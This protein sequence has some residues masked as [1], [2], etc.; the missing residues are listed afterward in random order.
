MAILAPTWGNVGSILTPTSPSWFQLGY[1]GAF[2]GHVS[3]RLDAFGLIL[4]ALGTPKIVK[5]IKGFCGFSRYTH[6]L[7][8]VSIY[9]LIVAHL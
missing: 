3:L 1:L 5:K 4:S 2:L 8:D 6:M 7:V 9:W